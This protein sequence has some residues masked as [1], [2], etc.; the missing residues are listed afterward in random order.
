[1]ADKIADRHLKYAI[2]L[3]SSGVEGSGMVCQDKMCDEK[4]NFVT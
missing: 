3:C 2:V 1:M 4:D